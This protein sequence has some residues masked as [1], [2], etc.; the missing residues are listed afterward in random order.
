MP[1]LGQLD[2]EPEGTPSR[3]AALLSK[4]QL[5]TLVAHES[6]NSPPPFSP[7]AAGIHLSSPMSHGQSVHDARQLPTAFVCTS[8]RAQGPENHQDPCCR[9]MALP[10]NGARFCCRTALQPLCQ[11]PS[12]RR[13][14][15]R[16][17]THLVFG[18]GAVL[19][20]ARAQ[21]Q[22]NAARS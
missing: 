13:S 7:C 6:M 1:G 17:Q 15:R 18:K 2:W 9:A 5:R 19:D 14:A 8:H 20:S 16:R 22:L 12:C 21:V 11:V 10:D 3:E 4:V